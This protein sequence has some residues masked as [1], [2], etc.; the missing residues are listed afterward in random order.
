MKTNSYRSGTSVSLAALMALGGGL[1]LPSGQAAAQD[2]AFAL[3]EI[4]VTAQFRE[5][6]LQDTPIAITAMSDEMM[7]MRGQSTIYEVTQQAP[8]V[9]IKRNAGPFGASTTAFIRGVGQGDFNFALEPGVGMYI[10]DVYFPTMTGSAFEIVDLER[11]EVLR[12]PQGTLQGRN[13]AGG[14]VRLITRKPD[15]EGG[16]Y[17][18]ATT[19]RFGLFSGR[20]AGEF[21][22]AEDLFARVSLA[23]T[24]KN[25]YV[26][27]RD[28]ACDQPE[29]AAEL[30]LGSL[31][32]GGADCK[33]GTLGGRSYLAGRAAVRWIASDKLEFNFTADL[34]NDDSEASAAVLVD[35]AVIPNIP[36]YGTVTPGY[37]PWFVP[38]EGSFIN[39]ETFSNPTAA[40]PYSTPP[41][42]EFYGWGM[43]LTADYFINDNF[44]L[45]SITSYRELSNDFSISHDGSPLN[46]ETGFNELKGHSFQE[47]VRLNGTFDFVDFTVGA[48][49]FEQKNTNRNRVSLGYNAPALDFISE[50]IA[51]SRSMALFGHAVWHL[52]DRFSLTTGLRYSDEKKDQLLGRLNSADGGLTPDPFFNLP[53][54][55]APVVTFK[56]DRIDYRVSLDYHLTDA[57]MVYAT[58]STG[59]KSGGVSPRFFFPSHILPFGE[60]EVT[61]W[62]AGLKADL[63]DNLMR[64]NAAGFYNEYTD[65][66]SG[67][68]GSVC[69]ELTPSA[70]CLV[71]G[72]FVDSD[73]WGAELEV[74]VYP[75]P[76]T[77][78]DFSGSWIGAKYTRISEL[79]L[80]NPNFIAN[81]SAPPGIPEWKWGVGAQHTFNVGDAG[82]ITPRVDVNYEAKRKPNVTNL[83]A[84]PAFTVVNARLTWRDGQEAWE[85]SVGVT[86]LF[87]KYYY[88]NIFD[89]SSFGGW[90]G[91]QP[92]EPREWYLTVRR[93]F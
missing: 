18:E 32:G 36:T 56:T 63:L 70:P 76:D 27:R 1:M 14:S 92:A 35:T 69:P 45:K 15:G 54:G 58:H 87:D 71:T 85:A 33:I 7:R 38:P 65:Q 25:G 20:A 40:N 9:Q 82:S 34:T 55:Y 88:H 49:Y 60:E 29:M 44:A 41:I 42:N 26:E 77:I 2:G 4:V 13:A 11:V 21:T 75:T 57:M 22:I 53:G 81:P 62:E 37:G 78:I 16:G 10:D 64:F 67:A 89:I 72:N 91:G 46:G 66:Q 50:E 31:S 52:T 80:A 48:F 47:E 28:F 59:Y 79:T 12:G 73:Y 68:P 30:G 24:S 51:D 39:Y 8:N 93:N 5:Q 23:G 43:A 19:G 74:T 90:T 84:V 6:R 83:M 61:A 3:E 86:N 17:V